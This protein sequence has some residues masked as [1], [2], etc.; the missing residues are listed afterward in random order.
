MAPKGGA[1][2]G[3]AVGG[4]G[5]PSED[6]KKGA[7]K[8][9]GAQQIDVRH[10]LVCLLLLSSTSPYSPS[11]RCSAFQHVTNPTSQ[12]EKHARKEEALAKLKA[13]EK[14]DTV[15]RE[16]SEDKANRG[17]WHTNKEEL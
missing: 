17:M 2:G 16:F 14:F 8:V 3:K 9:K 6:D 5:K 4:K 15:A 13:G 11:S 10:I 7:G 12:C 1:K